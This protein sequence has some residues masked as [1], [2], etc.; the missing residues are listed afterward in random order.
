MLRR[1][2]L[3]IAVL[4]FSVPPCIPQG[5]TTIQMRP[6]KAQRL[7][8]I[9]TVG[10]DNTQ[11][12]NGAHVEEC[13]SGWHHVLASTMTDDN[14]RFHLTPTG[15]HPIHYIRIYAPGLN[16]SEYLVRLSRFAPAELHLEIQVG[17]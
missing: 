5:N 4:A 14:G 12:I 2:L 15:K 17:T 16:I 6:V 3:A 13:D 1:R 11:P 9:V 8:G 10:T 7:A